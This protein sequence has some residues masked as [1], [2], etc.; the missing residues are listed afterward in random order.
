[1][2]SAIN[3]NRTVQ[4]VLLA[5]L[6]LGAGFILMKG[7]GGSESESSAPTS[8]ADSGGVA[9]TP[10]PLDGS[11]STGAASTIGS[12][13][14]SSGAAQ[15]TPAVPANLIPGSGVPKSLL[16]SYQHGN[17]V[18]LLVV[19]DGGTDDALVRNSLGAL[20][21][22][23]G[24]SV[25]VT[26][27]KRIARYAWLTQGADVTDLPALVI[28]RPRGLTKGVPTVTVSYGFR[29]AASVLQAAKDA[30]YKGPTHLPYHP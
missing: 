7:G 13:P 24:L 15:S 5:V 21:G 17:G 10:A 25:Y 8:S 12:A 19:R 3:D 16:A 22:V 18:A 20:S 23:P 6:V 2:R 26:N 30:L 4:L 29:D 28:L 11:T 27:A 14:A 9:S 1:M